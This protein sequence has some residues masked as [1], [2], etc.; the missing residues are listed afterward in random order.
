MSSRKSGGRG[1]FFRFDVEFQSQLPAL[2]DVD[3]MFKAA[4]IARKVARRSAAMR[5]LGKCHRAQ[6]F[7]FELDP[8]RPPRFASGVYECA[9]Y[10]L[11]R[12]RAGTVE[13][14]TF[15]HQLYNNST[16][17]RFQE[18]MQP[19]AIQRLDGTDSTGNFR[20]EII[21]SLPTKEHHFEISLEEGSSASI[22]HISGSPFSLDSLI[23]QQSIDTKFG[24]EDHQQPVNISSA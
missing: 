3:S 8:S 11:C 12:L 14:E 2:D 17:F 18:R 1:E 13:F 4:K 24:T 22:C 16:S 23:K 7:F 20:Q 15:M 19:G 21:F 9:G 5:Q 6:L 10:I